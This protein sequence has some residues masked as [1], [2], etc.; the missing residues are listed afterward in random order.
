MK[1]DPIPVTGP[2]AADLPPMSGAKAAN[3]RLLSLHG[4]TVPPTLFLPPAAYGA[5][6]RQAGLAER[7]DALTGSLRKGMRWEEIWD[8]SLE[9]R[10]A[11]LRS[12]FP[13]DLAEPILKAA[14]ARLPTSPLAVRSCSPDEDSGF[15]HAGMHDSILDVRGEAELLRAVRAVWASLWTDRA[16]LYRREMGLEAATSDMGVLIQPMIRGSVSGVLFTTSPVDEATAVIEA[17]S[18]LARDV[19]EDREGTE[20]VVMKR[21]GV[22]ELSRTG[23]SEPVLE[24]EKARELLELG[25]RVEKLF[26][27][28]QDIEWTFSDTGPVILQARP[29]T[30]LARTAD[31]A[32]WNERDKRPW[33]LSLTRSHENLLELR[34]RIEGHILPGMLGDSERM[35]GVNLQAMGPAEIETEV[36]RRRESLDHWRDTYWREL[37]PFA[38]AVRQFG[39]L[40]NDAV[41]TEDPFEFTALL[42][43]QDLLAV[44]RNDLLAELAG[45]VRMDSALAAR[46]KD[47]DIPAHGPFAQKLDEF[48]GNFGDLSCGTS[49]CE[50]GAQGIVRLILELSRREPAR[51]RIVGAADLEKRFL[52]ALPDE[53]RD[54]GASVLDLARTSY[55]LRDDDNLYLGKI[56]ARHDEALA[57]AQALG[58]NMDHAALEGRASLPKGNAWAGEDVHTGTGARLPGWAAA[59]GVARGQARVVTDPDGLFSFRS[60]E[61]LVCDALDP[62]MT[63]VVPLAAGIVE[64]RGGMLVHGAIIAREYGIPC[65]TGVEDATARIRDGQT[66]LVDGFKGEVTLDPP[67]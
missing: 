32:G 16:I 30:T 11:F 10:N 66:V 45:M 4:F 25:L 34:R 28:S 47:G 38:H 39:M 58:M 24:A 27:S 35:K 8:V 41:A 36:R 51:R 56:Q 2:G 65:V 48:V 31:A 40:Y 19:V 37:I 61:I 15:S 5:F 21:E 23:P 14:G 52:A 62:N 7:I 42:T 18:G 3:L 26:G 44:S 46:L 9:L 49:W 63:F 54:F 57:R 1:T 22:V 6:V 59:A 43:G 60:G 64:R 13:E 50:E 67:A 17:A 12:P 20:R 29:V 53:K 55:R 33:Y